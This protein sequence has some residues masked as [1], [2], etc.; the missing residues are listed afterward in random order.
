MLKYV[1]LFLLLISS[2][3]LSNEKING[4]YIGEIEDKFKN[5]YKVISNL[6]MDDSGIIKGQYEYKYGGKNWSG[7][8]YDGKLSGKDLLIYW[9]E[10]SRQGWLAVN[11]N[12]YYN[13]FSGKWGSTN[14]GGIWYGNR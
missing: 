2:S 13:S 4:I 11:F 7:I 1:T 10:E 9:K 12:E 6:Q 5:S 3:V 14:N 8:F